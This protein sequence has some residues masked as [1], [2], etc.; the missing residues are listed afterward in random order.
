[1]LKLF[2]AY[3]ALPERV[4]YGLIEGWA[5]LYSRLSES[6]SVLDA[7]AERVQPS[8]LPSFDPPL[9][10]LLIETTHFSS[11]RHIPGIWIMVSQ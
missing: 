5:E 9:F 1:M 2:L 3:P 8:P 7:G 10:S 6:L 4:S 11:S